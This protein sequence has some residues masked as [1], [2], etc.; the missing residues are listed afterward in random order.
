[1]KQ[2]DYVVEKGNGIIYQIVD[3]DNDIAI[4]QGVRYRVKK[5]ISVTSV[6]A[7]SSKDLYNELEKE[8]DAIKKIKFSYLGSRNKHLPGK[9]LHIDGDKKYLDKCCDLYKEVGVYHYGV[10]IKEENL[11]DEIL[12]YYYM[13]MPDIVVI[14]GH[15]LYNEKGL[16]IYANSAYRSYSDQEDTYNR[17]LKLYG[18]NYVYNNVSMPGFSE[19]QTGLCVDIKAGSSNVFKGTEESKWLKSNAYKHGFIL[20]FESSKQ[21]ITG[22]KSE[23]WHYRYVGLEVAS[24]IKE[25]KISF[26]EYYVRFLYNQ[27]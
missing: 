17:Y 13:V 14:T 20:R 5:R 15:D 12:K 10:L 6:E 19:H 2:G 27:E 23:E 11:E 7:C 8:N 16:N 21:E 4:I 25:N 3:V 1:M 22:Y 9:I 24:Y 18:E 26:E